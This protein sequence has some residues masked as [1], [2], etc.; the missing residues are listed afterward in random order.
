MQEE[1]ARG[2]E[3]SCISCYMKENPG[4]TKN[5]VVNHIHAMVNDLIKELNWEFLKPDNNAPISSKKH[6]FDISRAFHLLYK[7]RD[8]C[9][10]SNNETK[11]LVMTTV[12]E[13]VP[14]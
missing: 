14:F 7:Y 6:A 12:L 3:A 13:P 11:N 8:G 4:L 9:S 2:E 10:V 1:W 5:D